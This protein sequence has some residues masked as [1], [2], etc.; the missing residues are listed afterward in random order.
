MS[1]DRFTDRAKEALLLAQQAAQRYQHTQIDTEHLLL[2]LLEQPE[3]I[4]IK[5]ME[6]A[7]V[8]HNAV[9]RAVE[10]AL[11]RS[12]KVTVSGPGGIRLGGTLTTPKDGKGPFPAVVTITGSGQEDRDEF[13]PFAGGIR[14]FRQVADTLGRRGIAVLRLD[15]RGLG[16][17]GGDPRASTSADFADDIRAGLAFLRGR[18]DIDQR[19]LG[20]VGHS[21]G[22]AIAPM[23]A[24]T[25]ANLRAMVVLAGPAEPGIEIS[26]AQNRYIVE[27]TPGLTP[28]QQDSILRAARA[29]LAPEKQTMPWLRFWMGYD[30]A[31]TARRVKAATLIL[32]GATDRQVPAEQ[33]EKLAA[34]IRAGGNGD[35]TVRIFP[36]TNHLFVDDADGDFRK[37]EQLR[38]NIVSPAVLGALADWLVTKLGAG[39]G[40]GR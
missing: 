40:A 27:H 21:E 26:M 2:A 37:Y 4:A 36:A 22:G 8:D 1:F 17:S 5:A 30:P 23:I 35:V 6:H 13:I 19:R 34:L 10:A 25:D 3:S 18:A 12:P 11:A 24:A 9:R 31:P 32:Q 29:S 39:A 38:T 14:L 15:D 7:G 33:A 20:L 16:A 28:T